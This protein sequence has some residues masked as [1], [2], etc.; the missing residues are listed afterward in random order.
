MLLDAKNIK[1]LAEQFSNRDE[2]RLVVATTHTQ[3]RYALPKVVAEFKAQFP[4]VRL[5]LH[6]AG[7]QEIVSMLHA[8]EAD[9]GIATPA[10]NESAELVAFPLY[11]WHHA[12]IAPVGHPLTSVKKPTLAQVAEYPIITYHE[13]LTGRSKV[14]EAFVAADI[15]PDI[16]MSALDADVIKTYVELGLGVGIV[17]WMA[18]DAQRDRGLRLLSC[19]R[20]FSSNVTRI[21]V[22]KGDYLRGFAY[23]FIELCS[24]DLNEAAVRA[25]VSPYRDE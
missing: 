11:E 9:I 16:V 20:L 5:V 14:D 23:R 25:A 12:V 6:Q 10:L 22:R 17:A 19:E 15:V 8:G 7:P 13:G 3:A 24:K 18:F 2:G 4:K 1:Q 21:A